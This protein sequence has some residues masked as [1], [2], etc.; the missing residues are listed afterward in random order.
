MRKKSS[1]LPGLVLVT[2]GAFL[3]LDRFDVYI[4]Q[5]DLMLPAF[6]VIL[7]LNLWIRAIR[8]KPQHGVFTG[9]LLVV[10]GVFFF[11]WNNGW[12]D[13]YFYYYSVFPIFP[14]AIG[15]AFISMF[16]F[17]YHKWWAIL[18]AAPFLVAGFASFCYTLGI[19]D[20][21]DLEDSAYYIEDIFFD[22]RTFVPL[23]L[24]FIGLIIIISSLRKA[25]N[26]HFQD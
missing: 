13:H 20:V 21:Y 17:D 10:L 23:I 15:L 3:L 7:G 9:T 26:P 2:V 8:Y 14:T 18:P 1:I 5:W 4:F 6:A 25:K 11:A 24:V 12:I 19:M 16:L 22:F